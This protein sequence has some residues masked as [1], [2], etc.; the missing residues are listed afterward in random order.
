MARLAN[1]LWL[2]CLARLAETVV[3]AV[4]SLY[5]SWG[6]IGQHTCVA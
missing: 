3:L 5:T 1:A 6:F 2:G 4:R